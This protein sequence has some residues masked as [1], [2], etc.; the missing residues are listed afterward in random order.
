[1]T[2]E[3][4]TQADML[5]VP[6]RQLNY[7][8]A[9]EVI[10]KLSPAASGSRLF[11]LTNEQAKM[12]ML[13]GYELGMS[14]TGALRTM[15]VSQNGQVTL[16]PKGA[17][18]LIQSSGLLEKYEWSGDNN[19]QTV[20]MKRRGR[21]ERHMTLTLKEAQAA[22]WK[23]AAWTATPQNMLR[24]RLI[25]WLAD[26]DWTDLL[27]GLSVADD[28]WM[29]VQITPEGDVIEYNQPVK[30]IESPK[31]PQYNVSLPKLL[32]LANND[33][34]LEAFGGAYP[35]T[36]EQV[37]QTVHKLVQAGK[38]ELPDDSTSNA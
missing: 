16:K 17:L 12:V 18:A 5:P 28:S 21:P 33:D 26:L 2:N 27:L 4:I 24:W 29:N 7:S 25:G 20:T 34:I 30:V 10:D 23:S 9:I 19:S 1:M 35:A 37:N 31:I 32:E 22:G 15:Y 8:E 13:T 36:P 38:L 14:L 11:G 6:K 3:L